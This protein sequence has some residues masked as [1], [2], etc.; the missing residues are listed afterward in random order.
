MM[1]DTLR[2]MIETQADEVMARL[3]QCR[4]RREAVVQELLATYHAN[5]SSVD[6][7]TMAVLIYVLRSGASYSAIT[8]MDTV[9]P[10]PECRR[11]LER[12][13]AYERRVWSFYLITHD[14]PGE[15]DQHVA[16]LELQREQN[17]FALSV[18]YLETDALGRICGDWRDAVELSPAQAAQYMRDTRDGG[19]GCEEWTEEQIAF[20]TESLDWSNRSACGWYRQNPN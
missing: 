6:P 18:Q 17:Q 15:N 19:W 3:K 16:W 13:I 1:S 2:D 11:L 8:R 9:T 10:W 7:V 20:F 12:E 14:E 4:D 5:Q